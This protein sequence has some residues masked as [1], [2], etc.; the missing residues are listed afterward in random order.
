MGGPGRDHVN[1]DEMTFGEMR[2][3]EPLRKRP[4]DHDHRLACLTCAQPAGDDLPIFLDHK[5]AIAVERHAASDLAVE[6]GGVLLGKEC[7]DPAA[8]RPYVIITD[9]L[10]AAHYE[11]SQ[12]SFTYTHDSWEAIT[13]ERD[14]LFPD[15]DIVGWYHTHPNFGIF[16]S[17]HDLFIHK[18]FF[19]QPLQVAYVVDPINQTRGF[20]QWKGRT[21]AAVGGFHLTAERRERQA[22]A[23]AADELE[24]VRTA[25]ADVS[26][27]GLERELIT[28]MTR[29]E[30]MQAARAG[31]VEPITMA[32]AAGAA[33]AI[34]GGLL[35]AAI[36]MFVQLADRVERQE[37][38]LAPLAAAVDKLADG[39]RLAMDV[40]REELNEDPSLFAE[41]YAAAARASD[42]A[43]RRLE[44]EREINETLADKAKD[45]ET[46]LTALAAEHQSAL[47]SLEAAASS[48]K[49]A[50]ELKARLEKAEKLATSQKKKLDQLGG[51][52]DTEP[53]KAAESL[54]HELER[55][56]YAAYAG[57]GA[58][59]LLSLGL[60][61]L[62]FRARP[63]DAAALQPPPGSVV[64]E[65]GP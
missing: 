18:N 17:H 57:W 27:P 48:R 29:I 49:E 9:A 47:Q 2:L 7:V 3:R 39:Q 43:A 32:I 56:R 10:P 52:L 34:L 61:G 19:S 5:A 53:G 50:A 59:V 55:A 16:L 1:G 15:A 23:R 22:L 63:D 31:R 60:V 11:N 4:P 44:R 51:W 30:Q 8:N 42:Q 33:G 40:M 26:S 25:P 13:R 36:L 41:R 46:R 6:L 37:Q 28:M 54:H 45:L 14:R 58:V 24:G 20:F 38:T 65:A 64:K 21:V 35:I 62:F 12:A